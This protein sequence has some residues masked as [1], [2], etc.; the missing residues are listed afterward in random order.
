[1]CIRSPN[2]GALPAVK[3]TRAAFS[4]SASR[5]CTALHTAC[6]VSHRGELGFPL[7]DFVNRTGEGGYVGGAVRGRC[8]TPSLLRFIPSCKDSG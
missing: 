2:P 3:M 1:M 8:F 6:W 4:L 5:L 7:V